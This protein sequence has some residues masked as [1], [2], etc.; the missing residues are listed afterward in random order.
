MEIVKHILKNF[1]N[2]EKLNID[3]VKSPPYPN[4]ALDNFLPFDVIAKMKEEC[5][6]LEW[7]REFTRNKSRMLE[8]HD[9]S[10]CPVA[11]SVQQAMS[12][13]K[14]LQWLGKLTGHDDLIPDPHM[15]GAGYMRCGQGDSLK[16]H[17]DFN[18]NNTI[19]LYRLMSINVYLNR[20]WKQEWNGDFQLW[21]F[22]RTKCVTKYYPEAGRAVIW[23]HH[24]FGFHGHPEPLKCPI[25]VHRDGFRMF[26]YVS[27]FTNYKLDK[28]PHRSLY[29]Y[30]KETKQPY[31]VPDEK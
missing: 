2:V 21:D 26:Y 27:A 20:D 22:D 17:S 15:I 14:F 25:E 5:N 16:I 28:Q 19:G 24:K 8:K 31:D 3:Y 13:A 12:S 23:R 10:G 30:D 4:I 7:T 18:F 1:S 6:K 11:L 29:W 9:V